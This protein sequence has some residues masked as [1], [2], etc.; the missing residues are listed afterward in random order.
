[1]VVY[2]L[3]TP[4][5]CG[6][7]H[8]DPHGARTA[9]EG[10]SARR[11]A[12]ATRVC[13]DCHGNGAWS[14]RRD[15]SAQGFDHTITGAPLTGAHD[16]VSCAGCHQGRDALGPMNRCGQ[17][18]TDRHR[19]QLG[20]D[21]A[22]CHSPRTWTP[23]TL[24]VDHQRTRFPLV[25]AH[26]VQDC[27][28]CHTRA[29]QGD[30]PRRRGAVRPVPPTGDPRPA[31]PAPSAHGP[32]ARGLRPVPHAPRMVPGLLRPRVVVAAARASRRGEL[33]RAATPRGA[34]PTP[35]R[36]A[37]PATT[38][39]SAARGSSTG[40]GNLRSCDACHD[41]SGWLP[42]RFQHDLFFPLRGDHS[43]L[44]CNNCHTDATNIRVFTCTDCHA[45]GRAETDD[46]HR[47]VRNYAY[48]SRACRMCHANGRAD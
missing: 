17:C 18:H 34:T 12:D 39:T 27:V 31:A 10:T 6:R 43:A 40:V 28:R 42:A 37:S 29:T 20:E 46:D 25:G 11:L 22:R 16:R 35:R 33:P 13:A 14:M 23:D 19:G 21:C 2:R 7:C 47:G 45:H 38:A 15:A 36:P 41:P 48:E 9:T 8:A 26:A 3:D 4:P 5:S 44:S 30:F 32:P 1:M 24:L